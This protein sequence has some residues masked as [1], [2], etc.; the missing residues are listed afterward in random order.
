MKDTMLIFD[1][2]GT[3]WDS[4]VNVAASWNEVLDKECP[5]LSGITEET[6]HSVMGKP[7]DVIAESLMP[8]KDP[9]L[10]R[11]VFDDC[12]E[13]ENEY[14]SVHGG[15]MF[16]KVEEV[17]RCLLDNGY[18]M[19]IVSNCQ[20]GYIEAFLISMNMGKYFCDTEEWGRTKLSKGKN[21]RLV[22]ERNSFSRAVYIGDTHGDETAADEAGIPFIFASYGFGSAAAPAGVI[23][24]F[25]ELPQVL[26]KI[27]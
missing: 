8:G 3:L 19:A 15:K 14:V 12:M 24:S 23:K 16:P 26:E 11:K 10:R 18:K 1:L 5:E 9:A 27:L 6:I 4:A 21:I 7:M 2:D 20:E 17:L 25:D 13:Y 22:M